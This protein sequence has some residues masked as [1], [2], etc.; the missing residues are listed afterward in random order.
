MKHK[1]G[2]TLIILTI[3]ILAQVMGLV[4]INNYDCY[5]GQKAEAKNI[6]YEET[7]IVKELTPERIELKKTSDVIAIVIFII[8]ALLIST[9]LFFLLTKI[10]TVAL[11]K[12][13]FTVVVLICLTIALALLLYPL[14]GKYIINLKIIKLSLADI[15]AVIAALVLTI[16]KIFKKNN[17]IHNFTEI[18]IYGG[19]TVIFIPILNFWAAGLLLIGISIYDMIAVWKSKHMIKMAKFQMEKVK[20]FSGVYF[21]YGKK[22][23]LAK[24]TKIDKKVPVANSG[25]TE[26][27]ILGGGDIA[28]PLIFAGTILIKFGWLPAIIVSASALLSLF[29]LML[30]SKKDKFYPAMPFITAGCLLGFL[31][32]LLSGL[33]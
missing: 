11:I 24:Q 25:D 5:F 18:F 16:Y 12:I 4:I 15:I 1:W 32:S 17:F 33:L 14:I 28:F 29:F 3:F 21:P 8:I 30:I 27:A 10:K 2:A 13:W 26:I 22:H 23:I 31:I 7:S 19:L 20:I 6:T 9:G